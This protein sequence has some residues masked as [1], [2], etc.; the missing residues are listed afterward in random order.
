MDGGKAGRLGARKE[1]ER[2]RESVG[3]QIV[4]V[5]SGVLEKRTLPERDVGC[6]PCLCAANRGDTGQVSQSTDSRGATSPGWCLDEPSNLTPSLVYS[7]L[8]PDITKPRQNQSVLPRLA[9]RSPLL[10]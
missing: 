10:A 9:V 7:S 6:I 3:Q 1:S 5:R 2:E 4:D 8:R